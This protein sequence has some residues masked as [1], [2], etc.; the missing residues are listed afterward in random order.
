MIR[1]A[2][3][4]MVIVTGVG[5]TGGA[6]GPETK[7]GDKPD[8]AP[9][10]L[11]LPSEEEMTAAAAD[12]PH[13]LAMRPLPAYRL[14]PP[15]VVL[16]DMPRLVPIPPYRAEIFDTLQIKVA[17]ALKNQPIDNYYLVQAD[18][19]LDLGPAY[20]SVHV[21]GMTLKEMKRTIEA[22]L[23]QII[24][25]PEVYVEVAKLYAVPQVSGQYLIGPDGTINLRKY[26]TVQVS[27]LTIPEAKA[28]LEKQLS[29]YFSAPELSVDMMAYNSKV[30]YV[31][32]QGADLGDSLRRFPVTGNET[33]L[34]AVSQVN[35]LSQLSSTRMW[36]ARPSAS[37]AVKGTI[38]PIDW[39]AITQDGA[40]ATNYQILPGDRL[41]IAEDH[42][43]ALNNKISKNI[44]PVERV[45]GVIGLAESTLRGLLPGLQ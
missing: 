21:A 11:T 29:K 18:G 12:Q 9:R 20:G 14:D 42:L 10:A 19:V 13:E 8:A 15:D 27:G 26:G 7:A 40:T 4:L 1:R 45:L 16:L 24:R 39:K 33:V 17:N 43:V 41:F 30:Y 31:I 5:C 6:V 38:L 23:G 34:D 32:T 37:R 35:G 22:K 36:I 25:E 44:A 2:A 28:A 3:F